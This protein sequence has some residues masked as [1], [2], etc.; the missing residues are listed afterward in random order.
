M[1]ILS[2]L[3]IIFGLMSTA[4]AALPIQGSVGGTM[5][6]QFVCKGAEYTM[7]LAKRF[8]NARDLNH[9]K[10][11]QQ[12]TFGGNVDCT[13]LPMPVPMVTVEAMY[14]FM[15]IQGLTVTLWKVAARSG[16]TFYAFYSTGERSQSS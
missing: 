13:I 10:A 14:T 7:N 4:H 2:I 5:G 12:E 15:D 11:I 3:A 9:L 6:V 1:K 8:E 16:S